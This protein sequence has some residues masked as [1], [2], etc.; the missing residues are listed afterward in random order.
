MKDQFE[1]QGVKSSA[2]PSAQSSGQGGGS[3]K[4]PPQPSGGYFEEPK[5]PAKPGPLKLYYVEKDVLDAMVQDF[6]RDGLK[7]HQLRRFYNHCA[8]I[9]KRLRNG[10]S[11]W[12]HEKENVVRLT[13][14]TASAKGA[15]KIR[16]GFRNFLDYHVTSMIHSERDFLDGFMKHFEGVVGFASLYLR[17]DK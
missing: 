10:E 17:T 9:R 11:D 5:D 6:E 3:S 1:R 14:F 4:V 2:A 7:M 16:D 13:T 8:R 12:D 15:K